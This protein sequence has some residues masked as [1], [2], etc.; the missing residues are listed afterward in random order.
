M[1]LITVKNVC[2]EGVSGVGVVVGLSAP[3]ILL[4]HITPVC[5]HSLASR[6]PSNCLEILNQNF[7]NQFET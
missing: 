1:A 6:R 3:Q 7:F 4:S 5:Y 2:E